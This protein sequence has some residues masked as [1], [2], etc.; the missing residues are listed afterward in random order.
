M[1]AIRQGDVLLVR[2]N[3]LPEGAQRRQEAIARIPGENGHAH[4][5]KGAQLYEANGR[6][7][8]AVGAGETVVLEHDEHPTVSVPEGVWE[9]RTPQSF[10]W[11]SFQPEPAEAPGSVGSGAPQRAASAPRRQQRSVPHRD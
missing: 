8:V 9:L 6:P 4:D 3:E 5:L 1:Y 2:L 11:P 7:V 10:D